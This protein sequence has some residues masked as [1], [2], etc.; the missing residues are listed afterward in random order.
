MPVANTTAGPGR[1]GFGAVLEG[2]RYLAG[3]T[4]MLMSF[5]IDLIAWIFGMPRALFPQLAHESFGGPIDGGSAM[6][7]LS[8]A[9]PVGAVVTGVLSGWLPRIRRQGL[10]IVVSII[11]WGV[12]MVGFGVA[13]GLSHGRAGPML[14]AALACG[15]AVEMVAAAL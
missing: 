14:W 4:V 11:A 1:W 2:F 7:L 13:S 12:S 6:A 9:V 5:V 8:A 10:A 3:N 15:G